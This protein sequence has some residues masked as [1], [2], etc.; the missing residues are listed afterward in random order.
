MMRQH[1]ASDRAKQN[2]EKKEREDIEKSEKLK[3]TIDDNERIFCDPTPLNNDCKLK[4]INRLQDIKN[5]YDKIDANFKKE[6]VND[7]F[8][9]ITDRTFVSK[10]KSSFKTLNGADIDTLITALNKNNLNTDS[11]SNQPIQFFNNANDYLTLGVRL[12]H[13]I[14][15]YAP[16]QL[17]QLTNKGEIIREVQSDS[18]SDSDHSQLNQPTLKSPITESKPT[19]HI[20][21]I[22]Q[23]K[24]NKL[25]YATVK[26]ASDGGNEMPN[27]FHPITKSTVDGT[28]DAIIASGNIHDFLN[29]FNANKP[30]DTS[31]SNNT[32]EIRID[33][34]LVNGLKIS[35]HPNEP[36]STDD[37]KFEYFELINTDDASTIQDLIAK[38]PPDFLKKF[39][40][41]YI[42]TP[43]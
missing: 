5:I 17:Q 39:H 11:K 15:K 25:Y 42:R 13:I 24:S 18:D 2:R 41:T 43:I 12:S 21:I 8:L 7:L 40:D 35:I 33:I 1:N 23:M 10:N 20:A 27:N 4:L 37:S 31:Q 9:A 3:A 14:D 6:L 30:D 36:A 32:V 16:K 26:D 34:N 19:T 28:M 22:L 29:A 38:I